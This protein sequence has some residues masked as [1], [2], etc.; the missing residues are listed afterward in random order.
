MIR[1]EHTSCEKAFE[2]GIELDQYH[3]NKCE[4][5]P[6]QIKQLAKLLADWFILVSSPITRFFISSFIRTNLMSIITMTNIRRTKLSLSTNTMILS[7]LHLK[8]L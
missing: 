3:S 8:L 4:L 2:L 1:F 5:Q 7:N 6:V